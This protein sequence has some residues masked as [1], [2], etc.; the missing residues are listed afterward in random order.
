[1][2]VAF[3]EFC[4]HFV[5]TYPA[6]GGLSRGSWPLPYSLQATHNSPNTENWTLA[7]Q[8]QAA[9]RPYIG[10]TQATHRPHTGHTPVT[11]TIYRPDAGYTDHLQAT[12]RPHRSFKGHT[13]ATQT[14]YRPHVGYIQVTHRPHIWSYTGHTLGT[15]RSHTDSTPATHTPNTVHT[16]TTYRPHTRHI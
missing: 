5:R 4:G 13:P 12:R 16:S 14:I 9:C 3:R 2:D 7:C 11:Q 15:W 10:H 1:M 8:L 6:P